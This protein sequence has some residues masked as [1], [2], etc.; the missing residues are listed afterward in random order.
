MIKLKTILAK[1]EYPDHVIERETNRF[2]N[3]INAQQ[4]EKNAKSTTT[5]GT[6]YKINL[7]RSRENHFKISI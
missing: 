6:T 4:Q 7:T 1:N 3:N 2:I 5:T